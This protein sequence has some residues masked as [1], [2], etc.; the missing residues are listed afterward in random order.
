VGDFDVVDGHEVAALH[1]YEP[2]AFFG[3]NEYMYVVGTAVA[4]VAQPPAYTLG[5]RNTGVT[6]RCASDA[7][8]GYNANANAA[9]HVYF[10]YGKLNAGSVGR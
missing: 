7:R 2:S 10:A 8:D 3:I 5:H 9:T 1:T 4:G 6:G